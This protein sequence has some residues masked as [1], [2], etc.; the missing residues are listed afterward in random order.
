MTS[1][2]I[3]DNKDELLKI[4]EYFLFRSQMFNI[5]LCIFFEHI[6]IKIYINIIESK[7]QNVA[8]SSNL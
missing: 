4:Y 3:T 1:K 8:H 6:C 7:I 5:V 2:L